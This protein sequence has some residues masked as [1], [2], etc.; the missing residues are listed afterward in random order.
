[1]DSSNEQVA[2]SP[3]T[4]VE[5]TDDDDTQ[6]SQAERMMGD[7]CRSHESFEA[8]QGD[9]APEPSQGDLALKPSQGALSSQA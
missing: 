9:S 4:Y 7:A 8:S 6:C 2:D 5:E 3:Q 1:M